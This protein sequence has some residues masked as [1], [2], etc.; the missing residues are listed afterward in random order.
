MLLPV[1][2]FDLHQRRLHGISRI[3]IVLHQRVHGW[4]DEVFVEH[5]PS[6]LFRRE[7]RLHQ[8]HH[9]G[10]LKPANLLPPRHGLVPR[11]NLGTVANA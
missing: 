1:V 7:Q 3:G 5:E 6:D 10:L 4:D 2:G 9:L 8:L 11:S